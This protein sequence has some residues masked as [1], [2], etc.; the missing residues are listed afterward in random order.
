MIFQDVLG[1]FFFGHFLHFPPIDCV[2]RSIQTGG[3]EEMWI[4]VLFEFCH[5]SNS[6]DCACTRLER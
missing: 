3:G 6:L 4:F 5:V 1:F 2:F